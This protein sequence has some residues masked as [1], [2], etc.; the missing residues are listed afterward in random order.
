MT[1]VNYEYNVVAN[2]SSIVKDV[3]HSHD[4]FNQVTRDMLCLNV[5]VHNQR[6]IHGNSAV[7]I[8]STAVDSATK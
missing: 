4:N 1:G 5:T 8:R 3:I 7:R 2:L 6:A